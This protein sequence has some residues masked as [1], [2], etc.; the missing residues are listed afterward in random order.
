MKNRVL[1]CFLSF[2][3]LLILTIILS[4]CSSVSNRVVIKDYGEQ[5]RLVK[6]NFPEIYNL[7]VNGKVEIEKVYTYDDK[8]TGTPRVHV[9][10]RYR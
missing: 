7:Y 5:M 3:R 4:G 8:K 10:Y 6:L 9:S 1:K 2:W